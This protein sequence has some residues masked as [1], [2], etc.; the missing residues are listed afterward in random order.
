MILAGVCWLPFPDCCQP[1]K[2]HPIGR[3][4]AYSED[5]LEK[6]EVR[7]LYPGL[8][9]GNPNPGQSNPG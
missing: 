9:G 5:C 2:V 8:N 3:H 4:S 6:P 7:L 1:W